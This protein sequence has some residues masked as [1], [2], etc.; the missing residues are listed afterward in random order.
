VT[1][2]NIRRVAGMGADIIVS[3]SAIFDGGDVRANAS[4]MR[5][6]VADPQV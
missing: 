4:L 6:A 1:R 2:S 5:E 3:G